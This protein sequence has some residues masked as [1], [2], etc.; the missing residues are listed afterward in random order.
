MN[1]NAR[2]QNVIDRQRMVLAQVENR[3]R[4]DK[5]RLLSRHKNNRA[6]EVDYESHGPDNYRSGSYQGQD[7]LEAEKVGRH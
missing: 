5:K 2:G 1:A 6:S 7:S 3:N 4:Q